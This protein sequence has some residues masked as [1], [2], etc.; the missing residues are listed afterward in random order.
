MT[1]AID[2]AN[3]TWKE[4]EMNNL[5]TSQKKTQPITA[6]QTEPLSAELVTAETVVWA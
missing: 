5:I 2:Q 3:N 4:F 6:V 1:S